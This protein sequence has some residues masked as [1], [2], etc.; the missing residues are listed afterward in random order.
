MPR[1]T[2]RGTVLRGARI[3]C[4]HCDAA[5]QCEFCRGAIA[6]AG[7]PCTCRCMKRMGDVTLS[8]MPCSCRMGGAGGLWAGPGGGKQP[9]RE[10]PSP[11]PLATHLR[12]SPSVL[13]PAALYPTRRT[14][15]G[16]RLW[17]RSQPSE[18]DLTRDYL[19]SSSAST[20]VD[21]LTAA[22]VTGAFH[23]FAFST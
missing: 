16:V 22:L 21:R 23:V 13:G 5:L 7:S 3:V 14:S 18:P 8:M 1:S 2:G 6:S 10:P 11:K 15:Q 12:E 17:A 4:R 20:D 9:A 19:S